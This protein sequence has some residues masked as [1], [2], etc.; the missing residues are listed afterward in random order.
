MTVR[1][2]Q[3]GDAQVVPP[4]DLGELPYAGLAAEEPVVAFPGVQQEPF[5]VAEVVEH[6]PGDL[7]GAGPAAVPMTVPITGPVMVA[8]S[9]AGLHAAAHRCP[10][11]RRRDLA[12]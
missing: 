9:R 4:G 5:E 3:H 10:A 11:E 7:P 12:G 1:L 8:V 6:Q 2:G